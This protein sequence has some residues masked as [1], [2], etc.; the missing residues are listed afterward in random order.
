MTNKKKEAKEKGCESNWLQKEGRETS[1][2]NGESSFTKRSEAAARISIIQSQ[3][4]SVIME[5][6]TVRVVTTNGQSA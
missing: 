3:A 1:E 4:V 6:R 5:P 2:K